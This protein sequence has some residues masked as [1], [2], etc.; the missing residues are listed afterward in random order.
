MMARATHNGTCPI[1][2]AKQAVN[3]KT[4]KLANHGYSVWW[5]SHNGTCRGSHKLP[6]EVDKDFALSTAK[7]LEAEANQ[8]RHDAEHKE[9]TQVTETRGGDYGFQDYMVGR[10]E[11][12]GSKYH[13]DIDRQWNLACEKARKEMIERAD[14]IERSISRIFWRIENYYGQPL[15]KRNQEAA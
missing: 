2:G 14:A 11:F 8:L 13:G 9:I 15:I 6:I 12:Q 7:S 5:N 3:P 10:D 1:C 4:G